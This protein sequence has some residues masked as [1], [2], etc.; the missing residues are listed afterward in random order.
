[1]S[2]SLDLIAHRGSDAKGIWTSDDGFIGAENLNLGQ[3]HR[4]WITDH[5]YGLGRNRLSINDLSSDGI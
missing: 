2:K 3:E 5:G 4:N 1:M